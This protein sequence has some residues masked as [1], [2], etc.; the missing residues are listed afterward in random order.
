[1]AKKKRVYTKRSN[2]WKDKNTSDNKDTYKIEKNVPKAYGRNVAAITKLVNTMSSM[3]KGDSFMIPCN[4][5][6]ETSTYQSRVSYQTRHSKLLK[7]T[8]FS[9]TVVKDSKNKIIGIRVWKEK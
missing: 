6:E 2:F 1:M 9:S 7:D 4:S 3:E 5:K 8:Y